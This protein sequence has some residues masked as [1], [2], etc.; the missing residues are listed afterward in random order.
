MS[1]NHLPGR[2]GR[3]QSNRVIA[4][5]GTTGVIRL[6]RRLTADCSDS[7]AHVGRGPKYRRF[8]KQLSEKEIKDTVRRTS[9][10]RENLSMFKMG[11]R[12]YNSK[13]HS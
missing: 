13:R 12:L 6:Q 11:V 2:A 10:R 7:A 4:H 5:F 1:H 9:L 3:G 8:L